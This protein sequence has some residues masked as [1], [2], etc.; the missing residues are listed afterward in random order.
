MWMIR[1]TRTQLLPIGLDIGRDSVKLLQLEVN[2]ASSLSV[3]AMSRAATPE[4]ARGN[5]HLRAEAAGAIVKEAMRQGGFA[6][7]RC[8]AALPR[9][10]VQMKN[11]RLPVMPPA[12][13]ESAVKFEARNLFGFD[14]DD[15]QVQFIPAGEVRQGS[16]TL[17]EVIVFAAKNADVSALVERLAAAGLAIDSLDVAPCAL[18]RCVERF[19]RRREDEQEVHVLLDV[20][21]SATNVV[22]G[23]GRDISFI[24][25]IEI[26]GTHFQEAVA[27]RLGISVE[28]AAALRRRLIESAEAPEAAE[29]TDRKD[30]V[31]QAVFDATRSVM[32]Q[33]AREVSLCLRYQSVTFRGHRPARL[34]LL[35]G[36]ASDKNL[37]A[38]LSSVLTIPVEAAKPLYSV[39]LSGVKASDRRGAMAEWA[40]ALGLALRRT[41]GRFGPRDGRPREKAGPA[42]SMATTPSPT[43][44]PEP[45]AAHA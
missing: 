9:E 42:M 39:D 10:M 3:R 4:A 24:K 25:A 19:I 2:G 6:G 43:S 27:A 5:P 20:G 21:H 26:G 12:E 44:N 14:T 11:F 40:V 23:R 35:G 30:P 29:E 7:N 1:L 38:V 37:Q 36:E 41:T 22:I 15:A 8:V 33:L 45:E 16:D 32:E 13:M 17:A 34:R 31:R 28:E 18:F